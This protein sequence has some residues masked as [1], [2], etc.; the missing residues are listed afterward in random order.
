[1]TAEWFLFF[2]MKLQF[3][4]R[5]GRMVMMSCRRTWADRHRHHRLLRMEWLHTAT[6]QR[7]TQTQG[8][9]QAKRTSQTR[10]S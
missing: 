8:P 9:S 5:D 2:H 10:L 3:P 1:M 7:R 4:P 6:Q